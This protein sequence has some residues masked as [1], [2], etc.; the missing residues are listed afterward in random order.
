M[1]YF[2]Q[3]IYNKVTKMYTENRARSSNLKAKRPARDKNVPAK[4]AD[5]LLAAF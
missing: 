3:V 4:L 1:N 2:N 5:F